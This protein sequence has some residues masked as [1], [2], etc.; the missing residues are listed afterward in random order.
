MLDE[1]SYKLIF[2]MCSPDVP[3]LKT[4]DMLISLLDKHFIPRKS[5]LAERFKFFDSKKG[6]NETIKDWAARVRSL[7]V[8][9]EFGKE[10]DICLRDRF[11]CGFEKG[12]ILDRLLEE[13]KDITFEQAIGTAENKMASSQSY[14]IGNPVKME[15]LLHV[16]SH[17]N[18]LEGRRHSNSQKGSSASATKGG[19]NDKCTTCGKIGHNK[20]KCFRNLFCSFCKKNGHNIN[21]C[22]KKKKRTNNVSRSH[23]YLQDENDNYENE[24]SLFVVNNAN[25]QDNAYSLEVKL[26]SCIIIF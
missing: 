2:N 11:V 4:F 22:F 17:V 16:R 14:Q 12:V 5:V 1:E 18:R 19:T 7:A 15:Q 24:R 3:E 6:N 9:C 21:N 8:S 23:N 10:L 25:S 20:D 13:K 26:G